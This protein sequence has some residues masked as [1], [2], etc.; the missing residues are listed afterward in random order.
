MRTWAFATAAA[1]IGIMA[2]G[3]PASASLIGQ[4][5][6]VSYRFDNLATVYPSATPPTLFTVGG[7]Q[8]AAVD[9][10][11]VTDLLID[12]SSGSLVVD[13][14]TILSN[15]TWNAAAFNGLL[16]AGT[17]PHGILTATVNGT[18]TMG[19]FDNGRVTFT[20]NDIMLDWNGLGYVDGTKVV[21]DFAF[22][23]APVPEPATL[24]LL[25]AGLV[26]LAAARRRLVDGSPRGGG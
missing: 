13:M 19:G 7:G 5:F 15:P 14:Q 4:S 12:F 2:G 25:G 18:T 26:G 3:A 24:A 10:E 1:A 20:G 11:G 6:T 23:P 9:V 17:G 8:D 16:F 21:I 22:A